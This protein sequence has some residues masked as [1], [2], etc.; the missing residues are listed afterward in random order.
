VGPPCHFSPPKLNTTHGR[1]APGPW[2]SFNLAGSRWKGL[3]ED[4]ESSARIKD[5]PIPSNRDPILSPW[6]TSSWAPCEE[7][8]EIRHRRSCLPPHGVNKLGCWEDPLGASEVARRVA[9]RGNPQSSADSSPEFG[10]PPSPLSVVD[11]LHRDHTMGKK[12]LLV[13]VGACLLFSP[14]FGSGVRVVAV[15]TLL[16]WSA[17]AVWACRRGQLFWLEEITSGRGI[18]IQPLSMQSGHGYVVSLIC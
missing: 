2:G 8:R 4:E 5:E 9:C 14:S 10:N 7:L 17:A 18:V 11:Q 1:R 16:R 6:P 13:F 12:T 15:P 3:T